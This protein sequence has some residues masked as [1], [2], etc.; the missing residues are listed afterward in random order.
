MREKPS[1]I[2][3][4]TFLTSLFC[5][6][7][8]TYLPLTKRRA[9]S[10]HCCNSWLFNSRLQYCHVLYSLFNHFSTPG[11]GPEYMVCDQGNCHLGLVHFNMINW[12][13]SRYYWQETP[14]MSQ[15]L[16]SLASIIFFPNPWTSCIVEILGSTPYPFHSSTINWIAVFA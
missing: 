14:K 3:S 2:H 7:Q 15:Q 12:T 8:G 10:N 9:L 11:G 6:I 5:G 16:K 4:L 13:C 1:I